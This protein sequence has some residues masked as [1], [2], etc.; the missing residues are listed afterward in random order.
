VL[1]VLSVLST[2]WV[3]ASQWNPTGVLIR[4]VDPEV[5]NYAIDLTPI[6]R[7]LVSHWDE[8]L[9]YSACVLAILLTHEM[10]HFIATLCY[11]VP[12]SFPF[13]IP[14]PVS[15]IG[16]LG[17]VIAMDG[18]QADRKQMFDIGLAGPLAGL[19]VAVPIMW[20][21]IE[22]LD[23]REPG[24][25]AFSLESPLGVRLALDRVRPPGYEPGDGVIPNTSLNPYFMAGWVGLLITGLNMLPVSQLDGGHVAYTL[26]G[27]WAHWVARAF[28][29]VAIAY[30]VYTMVPTWSL[31]IVLVLLMGTDHPPTRD[32]RAPLG[33]FRIALGIASLAIPILCFS[34]Q[35]LMVGT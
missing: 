21:G 28:V 24:P 26:L 18:R 4:C 19:V 33:W 16:T 17:A 34:P 31:M 20:I 9:I 23:L 30:S 1:L 29:I 22:R 6:R 7:T 3:G 35:A 25:A 13:C 2:F 5:Q 11:R 10:G 14:F 12:A 8:G 32:D 27:K 15:P